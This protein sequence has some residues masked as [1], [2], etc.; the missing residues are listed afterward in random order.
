MALHVHMIPDVHRDDHPDDHPDDHRDVRYVHRAVGD[1][2]D[3]VL[4][5]DNRDFVADTAVDTVVVAGKG[6]AAEDGVHRAIAVADAVHRVVGEHMREDGHHRGHLHHRVVHTHHIPDVWESNRQLHDQRRLAGDAACNPSD[7]TCTVLV[8][9]EEEDYPRLRKSLARHSLVVVV[10]VVDEDDDR[11]VGTTMLVA[12][13]HN[14]STRLRE[15]SHT[16]AME[17]HDFLHS[18]DPE[19]RQTAHK[20]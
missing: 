13:L 9:P 7:E 12:L 15:P 20:R 6:T 11:E 16:D 4:G 1:D 10:M 8:A 3:T 5:V 18:I 14:Q 2:T 19:R 17:H